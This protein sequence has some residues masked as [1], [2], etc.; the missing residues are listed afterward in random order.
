MSC[1][2]FPCTFSLEFLGWLEEECN[3][4]VT[5]SQRV[6]A[7]I[8][9]MRKPASREM[10]SASVKLCDTEVCFLQIQ[11]KGTVV[12]L[13]KI[14][15]ILH[16]VDLESSSFEKSLSFGTIPIDNAVLYLPHGNIVCGHWC[17]ECR[18][19]NE[20]SACHKL[21]SILRLLLQV[22]VQTK[23]CQVYQFVPS[24]SI[25]KQCASKLLKILQQIPAPTLSSYRRP[26]C[27]G[28]LLVERNT[29]IMM[30]QRS[31]AGSPSMRN[32]ASNDMISDSVELWDTDVC[33]LHT[34]LME[35]KCSASED[36]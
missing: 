2:R 22:C 20:L 26:S 8:P 12:R 10:I 27:L 33:F 17:D 13:Q 9:S 6:R 7:G 30:S 14:H 36:T 35:T 34:Q 21:S 25:S 24:A 3:T 4:S 16:E 15:K 32:P 23:E 29:S 5:K 28:V 11:L 31:R 19:S 1:G 18:L